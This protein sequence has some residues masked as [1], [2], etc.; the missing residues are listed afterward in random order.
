MSRFATTRFAA[1]LAVCALALLLPACGGGGGGPTGGGGTAQSYTLSVAPTGATVAAGANTTATVSI[2]RSGFAG[3]VN[4][5][6]SNLPSGITAAFAP[7]NTTGNSSTLTI[8]VGASVSAGSYQLTVGGVAQGQQDQLASFTLTV[9][10]S[11]GGGGGGGGGNVS[12]NWSACPSNMQ[13][14]WL[15]YQDGSGGSWTVVNGSNHVYQFNVTQSKFG[16][17]YVDQPSGSQYQLVIDYYM[18]SELT[19]APV[20]NCPPTGTNTMTGAVAGVGTLQQAQISMAD[21][22]TSIITS[23]P[24]YPAY[25]LDN[26]SSGSYDLLGWLTNSSGASATDKIIIRR[27]I[28]VVNGGSIPVLD[29]GSSEAFSPTSG[30]ITVT[31]ANGADL[32]VTMSYY[33]TGCH[34]GLTYFEFNQTSPFTAY[35]V[36]AAKQQASDFH[37]LSVSDQV[38][39]TILGASEMF[40]TFGNRTI[41]MPTA[42]ATPTISALSGNYRRLQAVFTI[43]SDYNGSASF[44]YYD[45]NNVHSISLTAT[46]GYLGSNSVTLAMPSFS[47]LSGF[48]DSWAPATG[49][50]SNWIVQTSGSN[51]TNGNFCQENTR[52]VTDNVT[53]SN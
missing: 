24:G 29:F 9:T 32:T 37:W 34:G 19:G 11:G 30:M 2:N 12:L 28:P 16:Y 18:S 10:S 46:A 50:I 26:M 15:A 7:N 53:G 20:I 52:V 45:A 33:L 5:S 36:P 4:L 35:G 40:H 22:G 27:S 47:G 43:P 42:M 14:I 49:S 6:I 13:P 21:A 39:N 44:I 25:T 48:M 1:G 23:S 41:A 38:G 31:G 17:A 51:I 3:S 8:T